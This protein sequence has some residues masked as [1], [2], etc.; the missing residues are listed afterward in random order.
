MRAW[1]DRTHAWLH[2]CRWR[3]RLLPPGWSHMGL[4]LIQQQ[5]HQR[6]LWLW[7]AAWLG[8][9]LPSLASASQSSS[10]AIAPH[11]PIRQP[12]QAI[13]RAGGPQRTLAACRGGSQRQQNGAHSRPARG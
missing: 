10:A 11:Q 3:R 12:G 6:A 9:E 5:P 7:Q 1:P 4:G 13:A 8:L 2:A